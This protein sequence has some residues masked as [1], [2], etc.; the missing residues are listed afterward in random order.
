MPTRSI[1]VSTATTQ[2][3]AYTNARTGASFYNNGSV[4][5]YVSED[6]TAIAAQ[7]FPVAVGGSVDLI[8]ALGDEPQNSWFAITGSS[9]A[10]VRI[11]ESFGE[12]PVLLR[13]SPQ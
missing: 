3:L 5:V 4:L 10:D 8:R 9:T 11:I 2:I 13:P 7:G 6:Q 1:T 12:L